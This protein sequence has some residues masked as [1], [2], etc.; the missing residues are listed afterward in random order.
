MTRSHVY[1]TLWWAMRVYLVLFAGFIAAF[2]AGVTNKSIA[3]L[4]QQALR[5][6]DTS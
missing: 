1:A 4:A 5:P 2:G 3:G 6:P